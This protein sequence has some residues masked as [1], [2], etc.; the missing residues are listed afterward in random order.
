MKLSLRVLYLVAAIFFF[1]QSLFAITGKEVIIR[2]DKNNKRIKTMS[3][4]V[5][6]T[7]SN[8]QG[9][10]ERNFYHL[11]KY[12]G[13]ITKSLIKFYL[14]TTVKGTSLLTH[15]KEG[16]VEKSQWIY[17]PALKNLQKIKGDREKESFMG[18]DFTYS[19]VSGRQVD[20][21]RHKLIKEDKKYFYVQSVPRD[22]NDL[23]SKIN[24]LVNKKTYTPFKIVF[25]DQSGKKLKL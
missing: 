1:Q 16:T 10:R 5:L 14:P 11:K 12:T 25:F 3:T 17:F 7:I 2:I 20:Q 18:S 13:K 19:D 15:S 6:M 4:E 23:Y 9:K 24:L 22:K 21:D 8:K